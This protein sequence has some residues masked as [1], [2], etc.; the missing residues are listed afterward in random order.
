MHL[1]ANRWYVVL[2]PEEVPRDRPIAFKRLGQDVVFWRDKTGAIVAALDICPHRRAKL[3]PGRIKDGCIECPFH[4]FK[5][6]PSGACTEIPAHPDRAISGAMSLHTLPV[7]VEHGFVWIWTGPDEAPDAPVP[8]F[9]FSGFT[10]AGSQFSEDVA[11]HYTR[12]IENQLDF[13]HLPFVHRSTIGRFATTGLAVTTETNGDRIRAYTGAPE[14]FFEL[15][16]PNIWRLN[17]GA[18]WQFLAFVPVDDQNMRYYVRAYQ[19]TVTAPGLAWLF[20]KVGVVF[21]RIVLRQDTPVVESQ[22]AA[23][24][25]LRMGEVLQPSDAPIIAYRR[26]REQHR[27]KFEPGRRLRAMPDEASQE[28]ERSA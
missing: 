11:T 27:V 9:D 23:E 26:W 17:T 22:P 6:D 3:S 24:T 28:V 4:G 19:R 10:Y 16:G 18:V 8:F 12:S 2:T 21:S 15:L 5:F 25:R 1:I 7:R 14:S 20:G 13:A